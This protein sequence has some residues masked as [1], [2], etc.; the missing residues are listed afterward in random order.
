MA[1]PRAGWR[2]LTGLDGSGGWGWAHNGNW[3]RTEMGA[4]VSASYFV[5]LRTSA[6]SIPAHRGFLMQSHII[7]VDLPW[8]TGWTFYIAPVGRYL[9][10]NYPVVRPQR[11]LP[12]ISFPPSH[13]TAQRYACTWPQGPPHGAGNLG[14]TPH[15]GESKG[16]LYPLALSSWFVEAGAPPQYVQLASS[17]QDTYRWRAR[18]RRRGAS[19]HLTEPV[20]AG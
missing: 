20:G 19:Y 1:E 14:L 8:L 5:D 18:R 15:F 10:W 17:R 9:S 12:G 13:R 4:T 16:P 6:L 7:R 2:S 11:L 3:L